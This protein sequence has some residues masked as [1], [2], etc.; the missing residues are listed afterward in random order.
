MLRQIIAQKL[1]EGEIGNRLMLAEQE[2]D[3]MKD[4]NGKISDINTK[5][6]EK[7][8]TLKVQIDLLESDNRFY[9]QLLKDQKAKDQTKIKQPFSLEPDPSNRSQKRITKEILAIKQSPTF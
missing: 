4:L 5:F 7:I 1:Y 8:K 3:I 2:I 6:K 9:Q